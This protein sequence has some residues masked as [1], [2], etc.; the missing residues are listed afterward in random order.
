MV[1]IEHEKPTLN[2]YK[3]STNNIADKISFDFSE[4]TFKYIGY[5]SSYK[6][7]F[8]NYGIKDNKCNGTPFDGKPYETLS[9]EGSDAIDFLS[10]TSN[11]FKFAGNSN[12]YTLSDISNCKFVYAFYDNCGI[13][14]VAESYIAGTTSD[15][16]NVR[17]DWKYFVY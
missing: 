16:I 13:P 1:V 7:K 5:N 6:Y 2:L 8:F 4:K 15:G 14:A 12:C 11:S 9:I 17:N 10:I 3:E